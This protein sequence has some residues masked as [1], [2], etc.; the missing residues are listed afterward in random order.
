MPFDADSV[1]SSLNH[2]AQDFLS[3]VFIDGGMKRSTSILLV[4]GLSYLLGIPSALNL[5]ILTN[6]DFVWGVALMLSGAFVAFIVIRHGAR[7]LRLEQLSS[8]NDIHL[9]KWW[10]IIM[11]YF[12]PVAAVVLLVWWLAQ[13]ATVD[14]WYNPFKSYSLMTCILQW[15]VI[16]AIFISLN[17]W[18]IR[19]YSGHD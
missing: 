2:I 3:L 6:Q 5:N 19:K 10:D 1:E 15:I 17:R 18:I 11:K 8:K 13:S 7:E 16:I 9:G 14:Q 4:V 12:I